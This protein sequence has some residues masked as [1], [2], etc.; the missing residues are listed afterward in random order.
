MRL[1]NVAFALGHPGL[2]KAEESRLVGS[3][4]IFYFVSCCVSPCLKESKSGYMNA[5]MDSH[6]LSPQ[7]FI[8]WFLKSSAYPS[9]T[10]MVFTRPIIMRKIFDSDEFRLLPKINASSKCVVVRFISKIKFLTLIF[11]SPRQWV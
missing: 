3:C 10:S 9:P 8:P 2:L 5:T 6:F 7:F 11:A 4:F 1:S